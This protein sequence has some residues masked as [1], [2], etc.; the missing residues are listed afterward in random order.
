MSK[1][2]EE[3]GYQKHLLR[4]VRVYVLKNEKGE[5]MV[6]IHEVEKQ[7]FAEMAETLGKAIKEYGLSQW[8]DLAKARDGTQ[9]T[10]FRA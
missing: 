9:V 7:K 4:D 10:F 2:I 6:Y 8:F 5:I 1:Q 3:N